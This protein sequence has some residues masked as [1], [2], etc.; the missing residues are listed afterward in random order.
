MIIQHP[1]PPV[2]FFRGRKLEVG[3]VRREDGLWVWWRR[4]RK[5]LRQGHAGHWFYLR[6][7]WVVS[8]ALLEQ[9]EPWAAK[10]IYQDEDGGLWRIE[11]TSVREVGEPVEILGDPHLSVA[12]RYWR[13]EP[14]SRPKAVQTSIFGSP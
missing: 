9:A 12:E 10:I 3:G 14:P 6:S 4:V 2:L 8:L 13:Y 11:T 7:A 5:Q 1:T